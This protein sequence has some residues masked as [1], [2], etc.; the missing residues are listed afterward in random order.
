MKAVQVKKPG[1]FI[2]TDVPLPNIG[3]RDVLIKVVSVGLCGTDMHI[4]NGEYE[5]VYPII[6]G[7]EFSGIV[8]EVGKEVEYFKPGDRVTADPNIPCHR[9][10]KCKKGYI[11]QC[12][13]L[14]AAG[15]TRDGAFAEFVV[16]P[17]GVVFNIYDIP[18]QTAAMIEPL[19]CVIWGLKRV[20]PNPGD[21]ALVFGAGP[22]GCL[23]TQGLKSYGVTQITVIDLNGWRLELVKG[24]GATEPIKL[25]RSTYLPE[26][27]Q[28]RDYQIV[29]DATGVSHVLENA[30]NFLKPRGKLWVF[31]VVPPSETIRFS[32]Y[33][34]FRKDLTIIGSFAVNQTFNEA[35]SLIKSGTI[36]LDPLI[37]H[38]IPLDQFKEAI[39]L[40][41]SD[42]HRMKIQIII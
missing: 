10:P 2:L 13:N 22:M 20:K 18:F 11:N 38:Q 35:I 31:G 37:S 8:A 42:P 29:V 21:S 36:K 33:D 1:E 23:V 26:R 34:V 12:E 15:V 14:E 40:A 7:H 28:N 5:A 30:F 9:C 6:P 3:D 19:A 27:L 39:R 4:I 16:V 32:P 17:E 41:L 24:L 25:S